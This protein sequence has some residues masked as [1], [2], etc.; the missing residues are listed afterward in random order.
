MNIFES[1]LLAFDSVR[2]NK[3]RASLTLL[4]ISIGVFAIM[5]AGTLITSLNETVEGELAELGENSFSITRLPKIQTRNTWRKYRKRKPISYSQYL[6]LKEKGTFAEEMNCQSSSGGFILEYMEKETDPDI[7]VI[8]S[9]E[10]F[11]VMNNIGVQ[12]GRVFTKQ[13]IEM[14]RNVA[15]IGNDVLVELFPHENPLG[16]EVKI[17]NQKFTV[18]GVLDEKGA[19]MG[20]SQDNRVVVPVTQ[21]LK[22]YAEWW[23]ESLDINIRAY[24]KA[25]LTRA[26]DEVIGYLRV[27]RDVKPWQENNFEITTN[28]ALSDQFASFTVYLKIFGIVSGVIALIAAGV[29]IMNIMLVSVKERTKEI[30]IRKAVGAKRFWILMQFII[31][32]ITLCQI[33]GAVGIVFGIVG[34]N[35]L[36]ASLSLD[37]TIPVFW[38]VVSILICTVLGLAFGSYPAWKAAKL[39]PIDALRY[40]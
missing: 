12:A 25:F 39:D 6:E 20:Q 22:Y 27:I 35:I 10:G 8:G 17:R 14:N 40:E 24:N 37:L 5:L 16:K 13:D 7:T 23:E 2:V 31:E 3:L 9:D 21:F 38:I 34:A 33:G 30:G 11:F 19:M 28:E 1:I 36:S 26:M 32:A 29:G 18:I 4:S 15:V